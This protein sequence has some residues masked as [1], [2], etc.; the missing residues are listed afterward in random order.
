MFEFNQNDPK[1]DT[2]MKLVRQGLAQSLK[3]QAAFRGI[4][5]SA[6][7]QTIIS[8][9]DLDV[10]LKAGIGAINC[11]W[12]RL[13]EVH[14]YKSDFKR[15]RL[16]PLLV[17]ANPINYG[18]PYKLSTAEALAAALYICGCSESGKQTTRV[19]QFWRRVL[20]AECRFAGCVCK[21]S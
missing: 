8:K 6:K 14:T 18:K 20:E 7:S 21:V 13:D 10:V 19:V 5:L 4:I 15:H 16:L 1:R 3:P 2:G 12:N 9:A 11:S 17:A